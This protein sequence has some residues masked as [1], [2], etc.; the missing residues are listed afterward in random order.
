MSLMTE[1][2]WTIMLQRKSTELVCG[3]PQSSDHLAVLCTRGSWQ[4]SNST[5]CHN[6]YLDRLQRLYGPNVCSPAPMAAH[7]PSHPCRS[8]FHVAQLHAFSWLP[9]HTPHVQSVAKIDEKAPLDR[10]ALLGCGVATGWGAVF[11]TAKVRSQGLGCF[12]SA[13]V[14]FRTVLAGWGGRLGKHTWLEVI[15]DHA[16]DEV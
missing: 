2:L 9:P 7:T 15:A 13:I 3:I 11:N 8:C 6:L 16:Y 5:H 1:W 10:V 4:R 14:W 12:C